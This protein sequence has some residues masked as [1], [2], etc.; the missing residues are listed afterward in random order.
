[1]SAALPRPDATAPAPLA[2]RD[3]LA[4]LVQN[5]MSVAR[6]LART[7]DAETAL[8]DAAAQIRVAEGVSPY[9]T[10]LAEAIEADRAIA[11]AAEARHTV[12]ARAETI[13]AAFA[14]VSRAIRLTILLAERLERGL[15]RG[16]VS[17]DRRTMGRRQMAREAEDA[18]EPEPGE[19]AERLTEALDRL[20]SLDVE[21]ELADRPPEEVIAE[22]C[23][24][25]GLDPARLPLRP[26]LRDA[27]LQDGARPTADS[28]ASP[29]A[30][31][32]R[33]YEASPPPRLPDG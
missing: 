31:I 30:A 33:G 29:L 2:F 28:E 27:P 6:M 1:M 13:A 20:E 4:E 19:R 3:T 5:G 10:S 14:R 24:L 21:D 17:D 16:G 7:A 8:A 9:A 12:V 22:I 11:A 15:A 25:L 23:R 26:P 18:I 32:D